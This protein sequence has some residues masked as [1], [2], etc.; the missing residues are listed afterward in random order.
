MGQMKDEASFRL[1]EKE[2]NKRKSSIDAKRYEL[3]QLLCL[4]VTQYGF[5]GKYPTIT[6]QLQLPSDFKASKHTSAINTLTNDVHGRKKIDTKPDP[7][8][9]KKRNDTRQKE[10]R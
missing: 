1:K 4:P 5:S 2:A 9:N 10:R 7:E 8:K 6:G 3:K